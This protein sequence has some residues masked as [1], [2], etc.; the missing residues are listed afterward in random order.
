MWRLRRTCWRPAAQALV[1]HGILHGADRVVHALRLNS[2]ETL[3][4]H[5]ECLN[6]CVA[7]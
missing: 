7:D 1:L 6:G 2:L 4:T 3:G 5:K